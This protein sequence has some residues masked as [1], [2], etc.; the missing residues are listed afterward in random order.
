[1]GVDDPGGNETTGRINDRFTSSHEVWPYL[2]D[3]AVLDS[4]ISSKGRC[5]CA[6]DDCAACDQ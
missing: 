1:M 5:A 6:V 2:G 3:D 4:N